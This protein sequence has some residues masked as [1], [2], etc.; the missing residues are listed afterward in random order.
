MAARRIYAIHVAGVVAAICVFASPAAGQTI[1][2]L[3]VEIGTARTVQL[4]T[5]VMARQ[6][7][8]TVAV[9]LS[10]EDGFFSLTAPEGGTYSIFARAPGYALSGRGPYEL[11]V[12][13]LMVVEVPMT[14]APIPIEGV[15]VRTTPLV[16]TDDAL[17]A[18]GFYDRMREGR[19][20]FLTPYDLANSKARYTPLL[21]REL[22]HP[23]GPIGAALFEGLELTFPGVAADFGLR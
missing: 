8:D 20:Q 6:N 18:N 11:E 1:R 22:D 16:I 10:N 17:V 9:A 13:E 21:F 15:E 4:G 14:L 7:G 12:D 5:V 23:P 3:L 2:G 19:G